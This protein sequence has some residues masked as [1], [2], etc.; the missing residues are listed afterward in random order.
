[1]SLR[2]GWTIHREKWEAFSQLAHINLRSQWRQVRLDPVFQD[3]VPWRPGIY[4]ICARPSAIFPEF[5]PAVVDAVY[6][7]KG[8]PLRGRFL[9]HC[10]TP[11]PRLRTLKGWFTTLQFCFVE[12]EEHEIENLESRLIDC[13]GPIANEISGAIRAIIRPPQSV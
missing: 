13:L 4:A 11:A 7:G 2:Y 9:Y 1:V 6:V 8:N 12:A 3:S 5:P 10:K